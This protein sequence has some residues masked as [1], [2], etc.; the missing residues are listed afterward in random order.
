[1]Y[2]RDLSRPEFRTYMAIVHSRFSTNTFPSWGRAQPMRM[3]G[4]N[5]EINTL[6]GN[7]WGGGGGEGRGGEGLGRVC[8]RWQQVKGGGGCLKG[9]GG[10]G[11]GRGGAGAWQGPGRVVGGGKDGPALPVC[12]GLFHEPLLLLPPVHARFPSKPLSQLIFGNTTPL[13]PPPPLAPPP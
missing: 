10:V 3:L 8:E 13:L 12:C 1:M 4:H 2:F 5:G 11:E 6:R 7:R 9:G